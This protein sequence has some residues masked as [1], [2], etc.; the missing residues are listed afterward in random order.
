MSRR[1]AVFRDPVSRGGREAT[2]ATWRLHAIERLA[3]G[4]GDELV[5]LLHPLP[6]TNKV[7]LLFLAAIV[8]AKC[9]QVAA[10]DFLRQIAGEEEGK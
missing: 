6:S 3:V 10:V 9:G 1:V 5:A 4:D 2:K 7:K 8:R